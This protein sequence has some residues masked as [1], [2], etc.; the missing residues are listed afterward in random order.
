MADDSLMG[1]SAVSPRELQWELAY[2]KVTLARPPRLMDFHPC[3]RGFSV[4]RRARTSVC[5]FPRLMF[6]LK[7]Q[8]SLLYLGLLLCYHQISIS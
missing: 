1:S 2:W 6:S 3:E 8:F 5:R 4:R 7:V